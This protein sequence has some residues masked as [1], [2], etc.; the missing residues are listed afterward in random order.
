MAS[1]SR[2]RAD[3]RPARRYR[4]RPPRPAA[5]AAP[6]EPFPWDVDALLLR[7]GRP[8]PLPLGGCL[9]RGALTE[10]EQRWLYE[11]FGRSTDPAHEDNEALRSTV[12]PEAHAAL[13]PQNRPQAF[14]TW[15][16]PYS[17]R[18]SARRRPTRLFE[19]A[20]RLMHA[21]APDARSTRIDSVLAQL[22]AAGGSLSKHRD[23]NLSWGLIVSLG[24]PAAFECWRRP[25][26]GGEPQAVTVRSGD[27]LVGEFGQ[28]P[29]AASVPRPAAPPRWWAGVEHFGLQVRC[30]VLFRQALSEKRQRRLAESRAMKIHGVGIAELSRQY[31]KPEDWFLSVLAQVSTERV[32]PY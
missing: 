3:W 20:E 1:G 7:A 17:R 27:V 26:G 18:C 23:E 9:L 4:P 24:S 32:G 2:A 30:S 10:G 19:W 25:D 5:P 21:L 11:E 8:E 6:R 12:R 14:S 16:H 31:G 15:L 29:H 28:M 13:N 22:Y